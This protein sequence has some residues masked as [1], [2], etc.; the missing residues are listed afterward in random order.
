MRGDSYYAALHLGGAAEEIFA[1]CIRDLESSQI[2]AVEPAFDQF[3]KIFIALSEPQSPQERVSM[4]KWIY[5]RTFDAKNS[6]KH[7]RGKKDFGVDFDSRQEAYEIIDLAVSNYFII[8]SNFNS[9]FD[10]PW[11][12]KVSDFDASKRAMRDLEKTR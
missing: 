12:A 8:F 5:D 6:V 1:V 11:L 9:Y 2:N 3:K 4:E 7:K 10:L